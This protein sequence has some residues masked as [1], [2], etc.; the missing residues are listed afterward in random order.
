LKEAEKRGGKNKSSATEVVVVLDT[1]TKKWL[2]IFLAIGDLSERESKLTVLWWVQTYGHHA[3]AMMLLW[4]KTPD[5]TSFFAGRKLYVIRPPSVQQEIDDQS[6]G[7]AGCCDDTRPIEYDDLH[8]MILAKL[9]PPVK[10]RQGLR[11]VCQ[12][13]CIC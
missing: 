7:N 2:E 5:P 8:D 12:K 1:S 4:P 9:A 11:G 3:K 6:V 13:P 10:E